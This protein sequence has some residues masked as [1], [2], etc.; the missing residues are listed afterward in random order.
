[1]ALVRIVV[2]TLCLSTLGWA[3][4]PQSDLSRLSGVVV[5][6][7]GKGVSGALVHME[8][9]NRKV[10]TDERGRFVIDDVPGGVYDVR[11][12]AAGYSISARA[13][14]DDHAQVELQVPR[15][16]PQDE[17]KQLSP[18]AKTVDLSGQQPGS[19]YTAEQ[20]DALPS[21]NG[22]ILRSLQHLPGVESSLDDARFS[23]RGGAPYETRFQLDGMDIIAPYHD[24]KDSFTSALDASALSSVTLFKG[25]HTAEV[26]DTAGA[27]VSMETKRTEE[28]QLEASVG[29][30]DAGGAASGSFAQGR[31]SYT[32]SMRR[33]FADEAVE[34]LSDES[35]LPYFF[36]GLGVIRYRLSDKHE[37]SASGFYSS[38]N[39]DPDDDLFEEHYRDRYLWLTLKSQLGENTSV[40]SMVYHGNLKE[41]V[42]MRTSSFS[43]ELGSFFSTEKDYTYR[44][45][46]QDW[47]TDFGEKHRLKWGFDY[48]EHDASYDTYSSFFDFDDNFEPLGDSFDI[49]AEQE[50]FEGDSLAG[51]LAYRVNLN[52]RLSL[53]AGIRYDRQSWT[54][55]TN[56]IRDTSEGDNQWS[57]R[58]NG[59][60]LIRDNHH[61]RF[62]LSRLAQVPGISDYATGLTTH[63]SAFSA[64]E[65]A[66]SYGWNLGGNGLFSAEV[67]NRTYDQ[68]P[69][70][71]WGDDSAQGAVVSYTNQVGRWHYGASVSHSF[72]RK[73]ESWNGMAAPGEGLG[74][75]LFVDYRFSTRWHVAFNWSYQPGRETDPYRLSVA[76]N[77]DLIPDIS[78]DFDPSYAQQLAPIHQ[79]NL[80]ISRDFH[81]RKGKGL[82]LYLDVSNIYNR[83]NVLDRR[84][85]VVNWTGEWET[86]DY[87][88]RGRGVIFNLG[89]RW[90]F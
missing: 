10:R 86:F 20:M 75:K 21:F 31:G 71:A 78:V 15:G 12:S 48:R 11:V 82:S 36:D 83:E 41:D 37:L 90:R 80:R 55:R 42:D 77:G 22:D 30:Y 3:A 1:M 9:G 18:G 49:H 85:S 13:V 4:S 84:Q 53:E 89:M 64:N 29:L 35:N 68:A 70:N 8:Q 6:E 52:E 44:G 38:D 61:L 57:P 58:F 72:P 14:A 74:G 45:F 88:V 28:T 63:I 67:W 79:A 87:D 33:S 54:P 24:R 43:D 50:P 69:P 5:D 40:R 23:T 47:Y 51:Y 32:V 17:R 7:N 46:K 76:P 81:P 60:W 27:L 73:Q 66:V 65:L 39:N 34:A 25:G 62:S 56:M 19:E 26:G 16:S 2:L 59:S